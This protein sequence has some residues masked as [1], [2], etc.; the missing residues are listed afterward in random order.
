M[1]KVVACFL[2]VFVIVGAL[3]CVE[4]CSNNLG[5]AFDCAVV[6]D[7]VLSK[8]SFQLS[9]DFRVFAFDGFQLRLPIG[10]ACNYGSGGADVSGRA[11]G[12]GR[13][14]S[15][16]SGSGGYMFEFGALLVYYPWEKGPFMGLSLFQIGL[17]GDNSLLENLINLNEVVFGWT[18]DL[19]HGLL[20]EPSVSIRDPSGTFSDE[21]SKIKGVFPC[22]GTFRFRLSFGWLFMEV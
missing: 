18:F 13:G 5:F 10:F 20:L 4:P 14:G 19:G 8:G 16:G 22:Y 3:F 12:S 11:G 7:F 21:Y 6:Q 17:T 15:R 2:L 1:K 9:G